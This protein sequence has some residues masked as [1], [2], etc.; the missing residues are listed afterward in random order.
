MTA[1]LERG[2]LPLLI[3]SRSRH[4]FDQRLFAVFQVYNALLCRLVHP[5]LQLQTER[6]FLADTAELMARC[7]G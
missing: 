7:W 4:R 6:S 2:N 5:I 3:P 1:A